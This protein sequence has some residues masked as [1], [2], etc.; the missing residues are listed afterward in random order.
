MPLPNTKLKAFSS[1]TCGRRQ[2][3]DW[4]PLVIAESERDMPGINLGLLGIGWLI[5]HLRKGRNTPEWG[6]I[7]SR[8]REYS[9]YVELNEVEKY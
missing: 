4:V 6:K 9:R 1:Q 3:H 2:Q 7:G 5:G 8:K